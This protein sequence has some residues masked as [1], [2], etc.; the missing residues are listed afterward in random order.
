MLNI[1]IIGL[2]PHWESQYRPALARLSRRLRVTAIYDPVAS[3]AERAAQELGAACVLSMR[4]LLKRSDVRAVLLLEESWHGLAPPRF[5]L[6][7]GKSLYVAGRLTSPLE[8]L[9][10]LCRAAAGQSLVICPALRLRTAPATVRMME[11]TATRLGSVEAADIELKVKQG[12]TLLPLLVA[13]IDAA[14]V[15]VRSVP[16][17]VERM[18]EG[19]A[20][21]ELNVTFGRLASDG[22]PVMLRL[23]VSR[24]DSSP[25]IGV[26]L[27]CRRGMLA[28]T[29]DVA[30]RWKLADG[31]EAHEE[32]DLE[33]PGAEV[34]LDHFARRI[35]GGLVPIPGL[36]DACRILRLLEPHRDAI[37]EVLG[38]N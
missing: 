31:E 8:S 10:A 21:M 28:Q 19:T 13:V 22:N 29:G 36:D 9:D 33:R 23:D 18:T 14:S 6:A 20:L 24:V 11:L 5:A 12:T 4:K 32:L 17:A 1:G 35:V 37:A 38:P 25:G 27:I 2:G 34:L 26:S 3:R 15:V 16:A 30:L 7:S